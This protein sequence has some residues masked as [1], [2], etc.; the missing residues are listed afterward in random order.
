MQDMWPMK[1]GNVEA[2][3]VTGRQGGQTEV[4]SLCEVKRDAAEQ[5]TKAHRVSFFVEPKNREHVI[6][7]ENGTKVEWQNR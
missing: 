2:E 7:D 6:G 4:R 1:Q 3:M 5:R